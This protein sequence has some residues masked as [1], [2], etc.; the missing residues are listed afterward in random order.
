[1][2]KIWIPLV[3]FSMLALLAACSGSQAPSSTGSAISPPAE[4]KKQE[5]IVTEGSRPV[6]SEQSSSQKD[7]EPPA[8]ND[9]P[10]QISQESL[11][12][13][14]K[15]SPAL[16][17]KEEDPAMEKKTL[18]VYFSATGTTKLLA[19]YAAEI[20]GG[21]LYEIVAAEPYTD[22][23]L[24]YYTG[25]RAD[26]EQDDPSARPEISGAV[27]KMDQYDTILLG[28]P[29]WHGQAPR[30]ISTFLESY[31]FSGKTIIPFCTSHSSG[32]GSS[33][34]ELHTLCSNETNWEAGKRFPAGTS[35]SELEAWLNPLIND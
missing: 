14:Q 20:S 21:D 24:A 9:T 15:E 27:A 5:T 28:Y 8:S 25:G 26:Q 16:E 22:A 19:E 11:Q 6:E 23:D 34:D 30:I 12:Q 29:I 32:V 35:K 18:V 3:A 10:A 4:S 31:D 2:K 33:A 7:L 1:M 17:E 13:S